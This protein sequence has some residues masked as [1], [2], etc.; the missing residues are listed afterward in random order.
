MPGE[1]LT[2]QSLCDTD[3]MFATPQMKAKTAKEVQ[4]F[5]E[6]LPS[7]ERTYIIVTA[8]GKDRGRNSVN[9]ISCKKGIPIGG[10]TYDS[11]SDSYHVECTDYL[12][13]GYI[14]VSFAIRVRGINHWEMRVPIPDNVIKKYLNSLQKKELRNFKNHFK[15]E[16]YE[17][18][19]IQM[20]DPN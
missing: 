18:Q 13:L 4:H 9:R 15:T 1:I 17:V 2:G 11:Q 7:F 3:I 6:V 12:H 14:P 10:Y 19:F 20:I 16:D 8:I 5:L